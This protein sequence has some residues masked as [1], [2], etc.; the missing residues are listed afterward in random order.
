MGCGQFDYACYQSGRSYSVILHFS[1]SC[2]VVD[3]ETRT[4]SA[5]CSHLIAIDYLLYD[6]IYLLSS[7]FNLSNSHILFEI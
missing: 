5:T 6:I 1:M 3:I 2:K 4:F 7:V